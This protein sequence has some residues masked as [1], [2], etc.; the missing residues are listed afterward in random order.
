MA[1][2]THGSFDQGPIVLALPPEF[3]YDQYDEVDPL[4]TAWD[5]SAG[6]LISKAQ[7][8]DLDDL[9]AEADLTTISLNTTGS[10]T[11]SNISGDNTGDQDLTGLVP[12]TGATADVD[13][14]VN[15]LSAASVTIDDAPLNPTDAATKAYVD[16]IVSTGIEWRTSVKD[17]VS[18]LPGAP[19][20]GDRYILSTDNSINEWDDGGSEWVSTAATTGITMF[21]EGD[22]GAPTNNVG[23][24]TFNGTSWV[25]IGSSINHNDTTNK[26]GGS[27][28]EYYHLSAGANTVLPNI[29]TTT[30][31]AVPTGLGLVS[32]GINISS[33]GAQSA[34]VVLAWNAITTD[35]LSHYNIMYKIGSWTYYTSTSTASTTINIGGLVPNTSYHFVIASVNKYGTYSEYSNVL[36]VTT[37]ADTVAPA[38][39]TGVTATSA[40]QAVLLRWTHNTDSDLASY[41]I[42]RNTTNDS[43]TATL[44]ANYTGNVFMDNG[45]TK[46]TT[47]YYWLKAVDTSGNIS[48]AFSTV[49]YATTRNVVA[50]DIENIAANQVIIQGAT[51]LASWTSP[52]VTTID[53]SM[54]TTGSVTLSKLNFT[55]LTSSNVVASINASPEGIQ[56]DAD[57]FAVSG[58]TVFTAKVGGNYTSA[59]SVPRIRI[60]PADTPQIGIEV[61]D[62]DAKNVFRADIGGVNSG[63]VWIGRYTEG[64]GLWY[65][66]SANVTKFAGHIEASS[67]T[68]LGVLSF[69]TNPVPVGEYFESIAMSGSDIWENSTIGTG[70]LHINRKGYN[71][72]YSYYRYLEIGDGKGTAII[73]IWPSYAWPVTIETK[74]NLKDDLKVAGTLLFESGGRLLLTNSSIVLPMEFNGDTVNGQIAMSGGHVYCYY[75]GNFLRLDN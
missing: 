67:G 46:D 12:Y 7:I 44:A 42:Y 36:Q 69:G 66:K 65:D 14:G 50:S 8:V 31:D 75:G 71:G 17:I 48:A 55:P 29:V 51:T 25:Y 2:V 5:K 40:I 6:I 26:Q 34:Y 9:V 37:A 35:T 57:N 68:I 28:G 59:N 22:T 21:V 32:T 64:Q 13:L 56:I 70:T 19:A 74:V 45:R 63:D 15:S 38:T 4:F 10:I 39:V 53:G 73:K 61:V 49:A 16:S 30:A 27:P 33:S 58:S 62:Y 52:G 43:A 54:I 1:V 18:S 47:Y 41:N 60:F 3:V 24:H 72:G 20:D 23:N 11:A